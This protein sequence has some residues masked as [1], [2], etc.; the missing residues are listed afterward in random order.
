MSF[1]ILQFRNFIRWERSDHSSPSNSKSPQG[2]NCHKVAINTMFDLLDAVRKKLHVSELQWV[3]VAIPVFPTQTLRKVRKFTTSQSPKR[4]CDHVH[5]GEHLLQCVHL[6]DERTKLHL[7]ESQRIV[8]SFP[9]LV[10]RDVFSHYFFVFFCEISANSLFFPVLFSVLFRLIR[11]DAVFR[12]SF[13]QLAVFSFV[14][15]SL[16]LATSARVRNLELKH[17]RWICTCVTRSHP[18]R[19]SYQ[20]L[21]L[22]S[23]VF[24]L[25]IWQFFVYQ[26]M[27]RNRGWNIGGNS[28]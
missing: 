13:V 1:P 11:R 2:Q 24:L 6:D 25:L 20:S 5:S 9:V 27:Q 19:Q 26:K 23:R 28:V 3:G 16:S 18:T 7:R 10:M 22:I 4:Q 15:V 12:K 17:F 21:L 14:A 8:V